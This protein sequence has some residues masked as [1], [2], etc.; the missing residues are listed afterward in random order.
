MRGIFLCRTVFDILEIM[1]V[2]TTKTRTVSGFTIIE[3]LI[4]VVVIAILAAITLVAFNGVQDQAKTTALKTDLSQAV[5]S[6]EA[7][8]VTSPSG[9]YPAQFP[10]NVKVSSNNSLSL[11]SDAS[12]FCVNAEIKNTEKRLYY[13]TVDRTQT[14]GSCPGNVIQGSEVGATPNLISDTNFNNAGPGTQQWNVSTGTPA[15][16]TTTVRSGTPSDPYPNRSV[17]RV[18]NVPNNSITYSYLR[19]PVDVTGITSGSTYTARYL[20]RLAS[21]TFTGSV[22]SFGVMSG[23]YTNIS[24]PQLFNILTPTSNWQEVS[25]TVTASQ[26]GVTNTAIYLG[27]STNDARTNNYVLEFQGFELRLNE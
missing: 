10:S 1:T 12:G 6:M 20:V 21:G 2:G 24:I 9:Q 15:T 14:D 22:N 25:R 26:N 5:K 4:V 23:S 11:S 13:S 3:L 27:L 19:G 18:T 8:K 7:A 17:L 16:H